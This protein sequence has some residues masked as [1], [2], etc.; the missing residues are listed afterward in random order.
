MKH[1]H[2]RIGILSCCIIVGLSLMISSGCKRE[3]QPQD[4]AQ[5]KKDNYR[6]GLSPVKLDLSSFDLGWVYKAPQMPVPAWYGPAK[7]DA[8]AK[9]GPLPSMRDYDL[10]YYPIVVG[11]NLY[12]GSSS[13]DALHCIDASRGEEKWQYTTDGPIRVA[14][15]YHK[16]YLY[17]GSDDGYVYCVGAS[18]GNLKWK[19][20]PQK[21]NK[22]LVLNNGR[23]IS[24]SP[25][26]TGVLIENNRVHFGASLLPWE[27]S[28]FCSI[29][30]DSGKPEGEGCYVKEFEGMTFEGAMASS[31]KLL[32][33]PQ[34]RIAPVFFD[35][36]SGEKVGNLPGAGGCFV[37]VTPDNHI[38]G[39]QT[40]RNKSMKEYVGDKKPDFMT[41][42]GGKELVVKGD[43][44]FILSDHSISAFNR[45]N[46]KMIWLRRN[47]QAHRLIMCNNV[48]LAGA[49]DTVYAVNPKNGLPLWK[50][51]V[52]GTV[53]A[54][55][56]AQGK[57]F[58]STSEGKIYCFQ[59]G[60]KENKLLAMNISQTP[61]VDS[62]PENVSAATPT[63][64]LELKAGPFVETLSVNMGR[65][66]FQTKH[67]GAIHLSWKPK[68]GE[69]ISLKAESDGNYSFEVPIRKDFIY[70]YSISDEN[71]AIADFQYDNF[72]NF[73]REA[74]DFSPLPTPSKEVKKQVSDIL[75]DNTLGKGLCL[76][77]GMDD[78]D[79]PIEIARSS[80]MDVIVLDESDDNIEDLRFDLQKGGVYGRKIAALCVDDL[81]KLPMSSQLANL[82]Y[83]SDGDQME[84][85]KVI[86]MMAPDGVAYISR[87]TDKWINKASSGWQ[88]DVQKQGN[89]ELKLVKKRPENAGEWTHEYAH[90]D[91]SAFGGESFWGS[92]RTED[93]EI[94]WMGRPGPRFQTDRSGRKPSPLAVEGRMF[95]QG[96]ERIVAL[97]AYNGRILW[98]KDMPGFKRMNI[99]RD[100][101]NWAADKEY[102]YLA[103]YDHLLKIDQKTGHIVDYIFLDKDKHHWGYLSVL[104]DKIIGSATPQNSRYTNYHGGEGWYDAPSGGL[105]YKVVSRDIFAEDKNG[106][107]RLWTYPSN[108]VVINSTITIYKDQISFVE[109]YDVKLSEDGRG[110]DDLFKKTYLVTLDVNSGKQLYKKRIKTQPGKTMYTMVAGGN[111]LVLVSSANWKFEILAMDHETGKIVWRKKQRWFHGNH[112]GLMSHPAIANNRL[113]VKPAIYNLT[114]GEQQN[115]NVPK[116]GHGC[117]SYALTE[118][119]M[120]YRGGS[121]TQFN[122]Q[123]REFS[124]WE[125]LRP[126]CW[127]STIPALGMVLSPEAGG[128][129]SCGN[130]LETSMVLAPISRA[131]IMIKPIVDQMPD[132]KK[133]TWGKYHLSYLPNQFTDSLAVEI[134]VKPGVK[135]V[136]RYTTDGSTPG[137][138]S[139]L[140]EKPFVVNQSCTV[141][142]ALFTTKDGEKRE[143][144][145]SKKMIRL[146]D[147]EEK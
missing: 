22:P 100:C 104:E 63:Q 144:I 59:S 74:L 103:K 135:G 20:S 53:Y 38:I 114:T 106:D 47:Y 66:S 30:I 35:K 42:K 45:K 88:V 10:A 109:S 98:S 141:N 133:E 78:M 4:W 29:D 15:V 32:I 54:M 24:Y 102:L 96:N 93:F 117:A 3:A 56:V 48:L 11:D 130:W 51:N 76:V 2:K 129:C 138:L 7:E 97:D 18:R 110:G 60:S 145:R 121:V 5:F 118:E 143:Y 134:G 124:R 67:K 21:A 36:I 125:R 23:L 108:G 71:G 37:L 14:P 65:L 136:V 77:L 139:P 70:D 33:Q 41:F 122:F 99:P 69:G 131:P 128:G 50:G 28:Y 1:L 119:S 86:S 113:V 142:V 126:D 43:T 64:K 13:D 39:S 52:Q 46:K 137:E 107:H 55:A 9:S 112:G 31:G 27:K 34:G 127:I 68:G 16:G 61:G 92:T 84:A 95:V 25:V 89:D 94:R 72:F 140:Y 132:Y 123:T 62:R 79:L 82:V 19:Y 81:N 85:D 116:S 26:R 40:S 12:Y 101:S 91:N 80:N 58:A 87:V 120:F 6:S 90:T 147:Q 75:K 146:P 105:V 17:F 8:Y 73:K 83:V 115:F 57:L 49:T 111:K 44:S